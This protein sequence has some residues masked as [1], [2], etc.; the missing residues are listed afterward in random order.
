MYNGPV[1]VI[2]IKPAYPGIHINLRITSRINGYSHQITEVPKFG[3]DCNGI[4][5]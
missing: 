5:K 2:K 1:T 3:A 4:N